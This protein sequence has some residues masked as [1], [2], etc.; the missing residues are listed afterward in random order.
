MPGKQGP[1]IP[2]ENIELYE[3]A[4]ARIRKENI[5]IV[6]LCHEMGMDYPLFNYYFRSRYPDLVNSHPRRKLTDFNR[7]KLAEAKKTYSKAIRLYRRTNLSVKVIAD[8]TGVSYN[9]LRTYIL[10][11]HRDLMLAR[12]GEKLSRR[13]AEITKVRTSTRRQSRSSRMK[14]GEAI[15]ACGSEEYVR[16]TVKAIA[17]KFHVSPNGLWGQLHSH[18]PEIIKFREK[19]RF[20]LGISLH[21]R[22]GPQLI[23]VETYS[24]AIKL[25]EDPKVTLQEAAEQ[26]GVTLAGLRCY[27]LRNCK[28]L[29]KSREKSR[30]EAM[31]TRG[32]GRMSGLGGIRK[33]NE[34]NRGQYEE[35]LRLFRET[36]MTVKDIAH[37]T[38]MKYYKLLY[39]LKYWNRDL[40]IARKSAEPESL[41][42]STNLI[43]SP[44]RNIWTTE[45]YAEAVKTLEEGTSSVE[46]LCKESGLSPECLRDYL[47]KYYPDLHLKYGQTTLDNGKKVLGRSYAKYAPAIEELKSNPGLEL[48]TLAEKHGLVYNSFTAFLRRNF[49]DL[50][51]H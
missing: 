40:V 19:R 20:E 48:K 24:D 21:H 30:R 42:G 27:Y 38:G 39:Y 15:A 50:L 11:H 44:H 18:Y 4:V 25:L 26:T 51:K 1:N 33:I 37:Q 5:K 41:P 22:R 14:Y 43:N 45:K 3:K 6:D 8:Q 32:E 7:R 9:G 47:K 10:H 49:P 36:T 12:Q 28:D 23:T 35:A 46:R 31:S 29:Q 17:E 16:L 34:K 2:S 13:Q